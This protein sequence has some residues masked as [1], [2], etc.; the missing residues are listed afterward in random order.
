MDPSI[1]DYLKGTSPLAMLVIVVLTYIGL[2][3]LRSD[4]KKDVHEIV[5][6]ALGLGEKEEFE[7]KLNAA[8]SSGF[9]S[10][11]HPLTESISHL[12]ATIGALSNEVK[13]LREGLAN[14]GDRI[15]KLETAL[16]ILK[17]KNS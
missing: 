17:E 2:R 14:H 1:L 7:A 12:S 15:V 6:A 16:A 3:K 9:V 11:V 13:G 10:S 8:I 5:R 4:Q